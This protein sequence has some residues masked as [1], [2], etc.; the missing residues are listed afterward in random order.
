MF[1]G[2]NA[3]AVCLL[4][5]QV[6]P[7]ERNAKCDV[8]P[9]RSAVRVFQCSSAI[10]PYGKRLRVLTAKKT[11]FKEKVA[12]F[13]VDHFEA[14][15]TLGPVLD[16][17]PEAFYTHGQNEEWQRAWAREQGMPK[18]TGLEDILLAQ[19]EQHRTEVFYANGGG[20]P[21]GTFLKRMPGHVRARICFFA[22]PVLDRDLGGYLVVNN[23]PSLL[24]SYGNAG[25]KTSYLCPAHDPALDSVARCTDRDIDVLFV[26]TFSRHHLGRTAILEK[27]A[28]LA[29]RYS[30]VYSLLPGRLSRLADTPLGLF[31]P[32][33]KHR[34]PEAVRSVMIPAK[35][36]RDYYELLGR[37][38]IVLNAAVDISGNDRGN[39]RCWEA[40]GAG[41]LMISDAGRYPQG[42]VDGETLRTYSSADDVAEIVVEMLAKTEERS[43]IAA[44]GHDMLRS[45]YSKSRQWDAIKLLV[46]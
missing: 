45:R 21:V 15:H 36:G 14:V 6:A 30:I 41:T 37:S 19:I 42:M 17:R 7:S 27:V 22:G 40:L 8:D 23:F 4:V 32:L 35:F 28:A 3:Y 29:G 16:G 18:H 38:K 2:A 24:E 9:G 33:R 1:A 31:G 11:T 25:L 34:R 10:A 26:G 13:H 46:S 5:V 39:M 12:A 43:R 20:A 44:T